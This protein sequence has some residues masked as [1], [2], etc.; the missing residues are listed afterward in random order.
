MDKKGNLWLIPVPLSEEISGAPD[1]SLAEVASKCQIFI[2]EKG[3][4]ARK[5]LK[6]LDPGFSTRGVEF[7]ELNKHGI[8][9][10]LDDAI[11]SADKGIEIGLMSEAGCPGIADPGAEVVA[12]AHRKGI[13][14]KPLIGPSSIILA[15]MA[16]GFNGQR[17]FFRGYLSIKAPDLI[18][19]IKY[20]ELQSRRENCSMIFIETP[21]RNTAMIGQLIE[22]LSDNTMLCIAR[23][24]CTED[25]WVYSAPISKWKRMEIP[26]LHKIPCVF[27]L[28]ADL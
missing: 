18:K 17:F 19:E 13:S 12:L 22:T 20:L 8:T 16:S 28:Q 21:Y 26:E 9:H 11:K 6:W 27:I 15:L 10:G 1:A 25:E 2:V 5:W 3:K 14:V 24:L 23:G 4:T 7:I